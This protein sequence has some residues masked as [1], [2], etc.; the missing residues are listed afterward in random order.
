MVDIDPDELAKRARHFAL[1][2]CADA[3]DFLREILTQNA[4]IRRKDQLSVLV[5]R[6]ILQVTRG[7]PG[8]EVGWIRQSRRSAEA[9]SLTGAQ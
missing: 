6:F 7:A 8:G 5:P 3:G 9:H 4:S 2:N 1:P